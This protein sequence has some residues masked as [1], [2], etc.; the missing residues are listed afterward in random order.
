MLM[1]HVLGLVQSQRLGTK[2]L[3]RPCPTIKALSL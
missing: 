2:I 3:V 1:T